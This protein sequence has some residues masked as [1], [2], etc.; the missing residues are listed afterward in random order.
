MTVSQSVLHSDSLSMLFVCIDFVDCPNHGTCELFPFDSFK[1]CSEFFCNY[2]RDLTSLA[3]WTYDEVWPCIH[4]KSFIEHHLD[5]IEKMW[6]ANIFNCKKMHVSHSMAGHSAMLGAVAMSDAPLELFLARGMKSFLKD[7]VVVLT[8]DHG[9]HYG[10]EQ[11]WNN[12]IAGEHAHRNPI[13]KL[14]FGPDVSLSES[15]RANLRWNKDRRVTHLDMHKTLLGLQSG[16]TTANVFTVKTPN[17]ANRP[18]PAVD[19]LNQRASIDRNCRSL[20]LKEW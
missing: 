12:Y 11:K 5:F 7:T 2:D 17:D 1:V 6:K 18:T 4:G 9:Y 13:L 20:G 19:L 14:I 3:R 8:S 15:Q 10:H 16:I